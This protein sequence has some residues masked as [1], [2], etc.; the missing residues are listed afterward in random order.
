M[1]VLQAIEELDGK[2]V[3]FRNSESIEASN[4]NVIFMI[5]QWQDNDLLLLGFAVIIYE[6][7]PVHDRSQRQLQYKQHWIS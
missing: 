7:L 2:Y 4:Y 5:C 6:N 3:V 1:S